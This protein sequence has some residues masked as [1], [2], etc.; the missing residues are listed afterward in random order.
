MERVILHSDLNNFFA[1]VE[2]LHRPEIRDKPV[3]VG[4]DVELRHG[5]VLAKNYHAKK[6]GIKTGE[7]LWQVKQRCKDLVVIPPNYK[8]YLRFAQMA[9]KIYGDYTDLIEPFG[10]DEAWLDVTGSTRL[11]GTGQQIADEIRARIF[12]EM[13]VTA[14]V[15][16]SW[17]KIFAKLGSDMKK[18]DATTVITKENYR[19]KVWTLPVG[20]LLYV[21]AAT[22]QKLN[23][24]GIYTI[25]HLA[26]APDS[27]LTNALGKMGG[28]LKCFAGGNDITP[29]VSM[30]VEGIIKS[31]GNST[32]TPRDLETTDEV[33]TV[34]FVLAESVAARMRSHDFRAKTVCISI[35][36]NELNSFE[37]QGKLTKSSN[38]SGEIVRKAME[39]F[40]ES[41]DF[42]KDKPIRSFG[43]RATDLVVGPQETQLSFFFDETQ[44]DKQ[45]KLEFTVDTLRKRFGHFCIQRAVMLAD[46]PLSALN[47][48]DDHV[49]HPV[50]Y[51][52][53]Q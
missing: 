27:C 21:G 29:V 31:I 45:E 2:C 4:G 24:C 26:E 35:R 37:R 12:R 17:N 3:V 1:S 8:L 49:I 20:E 48:K 33:K 47:P 30:G 16:V 13:G 50:G 34:A 14:S 44:R 25:G 11:F 9:R 10:I 7:A 5:I 51:F 18:P 43:V 6:F 42:S 39:L 32:T 15:G 19:D 22:G 53:P 38:I 28:V 23:R 41:Y 46:K 36:D 52:Q 40:A